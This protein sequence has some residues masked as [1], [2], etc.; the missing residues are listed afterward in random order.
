MAPTVPGSDTLIISGQCAHWDHIRMVGFPPLYSRLPAGM[1]LAPVSPAS[2]II[3]FH[4]RTENLTKKWQW[5]LGTYTESPLAAIVENAQH[6]PINVPGFC[7]GRAVRPHWRLDV[8]DSGFMDFSL[9]LALFTHIHVGQIV[10]VWEI[11]INRINRKI[12]V[13]WL[14]LWWLFVMSLD[15]SR[16][17]IN[18]FSND[19]RSW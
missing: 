15:I 10:R 14:I 9:I 1:D 5:V 12:R 13:I 17:A 2:R 3:I 11:L 7:N 18:Y 19:S 8:T 16:A 4:E 6:M